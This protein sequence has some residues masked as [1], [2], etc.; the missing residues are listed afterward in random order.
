MASLKIHCRNPDGDT[1]Y[2]S[3]AEKREAETKASAEH[4]SESKGSQ[5][6]SHGER[7]DFTRTDGNARASAGD[8][9]AFADA[10]DGGRAMAISGEL[11]K[12]ASRLEEEIKK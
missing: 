3:W 4:G 10:R 6:C 12:V 2:D 1:Y 5:E 8:G 11:G 7:L 9:V